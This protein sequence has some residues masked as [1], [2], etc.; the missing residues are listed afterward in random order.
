MK[1]LLLTLFSISLLGCDE[2]PET[3]SHFESP[4]SHRQCNCNELNL[5][6]GFWLLDATKF[7]G[8]CSTYYEDNSIQERCN[9]QSGKRDGTTFLYNEDGW[10][11]EALPFQDG[12]ET[13][14]VK[15]YH[16]NTMVQR[17][18]QAVNSEAHGE[19]LEYTEDGILMTKET[20]ENG[21][22]HGPFEELYSNGDLKISGNY[23]NGEWQFPWLARIGGEMTEVYDPETEIDSIAPSVQ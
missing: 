1:L 7:T 21:E 4:L 20:F 5:A 22:L 16:E 9:F 8:E 19:W 17:I 6:N 2:M 14:E 15:I 10:L 23:V 13:G 12:I 3:S 11:M 18:G